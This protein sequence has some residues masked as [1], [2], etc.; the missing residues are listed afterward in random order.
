MR[1][2]LERLQEVLGPRVTALTP[3]SATDGEKGLSPT[4]Q[5][6]LDYWSALREAT[7]ESGGVLKPQKPRPQ[8]WTNI[9]IGRWGFN[10][11]AMM[12]IARRMIG[13]ELVLQGPLAKLHFHA[14]AQDRAEIEAE[15]GEPLEWREKPEGKDSFLTLRRTGVDPTDRAGWTDQHKWL[16][17]K[18]EAFHRV[19]APRIKAIE[20][21]PTADQPAEDGPTEVVRFVTI[22]QNQAPVGD[23]AE[24]A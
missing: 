3:A 12:N 2:T 24:Q 15:L 14:L 23:E 11:A 9:S 13:V 7:I 8:S 6:Q 5:L 20:S 17:E 1:R 18:L 10:L 22:P 19:L 4:K 21:K 16:R